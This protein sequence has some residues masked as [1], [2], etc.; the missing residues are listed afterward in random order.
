MGGREGHCHPI[1]PK[2]ALNFSPI[3]SNVGPKRAILTKNVGQNRSQIHLEPI[4][5]VIIMI[6]DLYTLKKVVPHL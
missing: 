1:S 4:L 3:A 6:I 2:S 5:V